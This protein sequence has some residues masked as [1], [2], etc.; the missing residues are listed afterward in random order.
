[1]FYHKIQESHAYVCDQ[2]NTIRSYD[3]KL[4]GIEV[5]KIQLEEFEKFS[6][7]AGEYH[8]I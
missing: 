6:K 2:I 3:T 5:G 4:L 1:M 7:E 8:F